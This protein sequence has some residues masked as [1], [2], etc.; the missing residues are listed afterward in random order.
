M[1]ATLKNRMSGAMSEQ[2]DGMNPNGNFQ[3]WNP[4]RIIIGDGVSES[5]P[6][7][8]DS[9]HH[10]DGR[11][12]AFVVTHTSAKDY[13]LLDYLLDT[14]KG[15][16]REVVHVFGEVPNRANLDQVSEAALKAKET[17]ADLWIALGGGSAMDVCKAGAILQVND[18]SLSD[19]SG[20]NLMRERPNP[21]ICIPTT[22]GTGAEVSPHA[23]I[24]DSKEKK[25]LFIC[26]HG[27]IP[28]VAVLDPQL[29]RTLRASL[30]ASAAITA[31]NQAI[32]A[33]VIKPANHFSVCLATKALELSARSI[34]E[35]YRNNS[36]D[37]EARC[38]MLTAAA[39]GGLALQTSLPGI[40][41][42][43]AHSAC[44]LHEI[45]YGI[46]LGIANLHL[47]E[48][49][50]QLMPIASAIIAGALGVNRNGLSN[51]ATGFACSEKLRELY[52]KVDIKLSFKDHGVPADD[53]SVTS[54]LISSLD[55][56]CMTFN[57]PAVT[58]S[59]TCERLIRKC[60]G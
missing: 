4:S 33:I 5:L 52:A 12:R 31:M 47:I 36:T 11:R 22:A 15:S 42:A 1:D 6:N 46:A 13:G 40:T 28:S 3:W 8:L 24:I 50:L 57:P 41:A 38:D 19:Y 7:L 25:K 58:E 37:M 51:E 29:T 27:I 44:T 16:G 2:R 23:F 34:E 39:M 26:D 20:A 35:A 10:L 53:Q 55:S 43:I 45:N 21:I 56:P 14:M 49:C 59:L 60:I 32:S 54:L 9:M 17:E 18:G 30:V 48:D